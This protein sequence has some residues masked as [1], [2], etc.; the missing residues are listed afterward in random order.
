MPAH[1]AWY[2][3]RGSRPRALIGTVFW[4]DDWLAKKVKYFWGVIQVAVELQIPL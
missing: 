3:L 1:E 4:G 2:G